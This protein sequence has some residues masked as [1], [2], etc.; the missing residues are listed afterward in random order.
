MD[1]DVELEAIIEKYHLGD[2]YPQYDA[3]KKARRF[4][5]NLLDELARKGEKAVFIGT[6]GTGLR[7]LRLMAPEGADFDF[8]SFQP[9]KLTA[10][11]LAGKKVYVV[12]WQGAGDIFE[13]L[14]A[15]N[16]SFQWLFDLL[17]ARGIAL[18]DEFYCFFQKKALQFPRSFE[19]IAAYEYY[20]CKKRHRATED[21]ELKKLLLKKMFFL[22][23]YM[24]NFLRAERM[25]KENRDEGLDMDAEKAWNEISDL[26]ERIKQALKRRDQA[27]IIFFWLDDLSHE[28]A[29]SVSYLQ[30]RRTHSYFFTEAYTMTP[31]TNPTYRSVFLGVRICSEV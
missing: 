18:D 3:T 16:V 23:L 31:H 25:L 8:F 10:E 28:R 7:Y 17:E 1:I 19:N 26:L 14:I 20:L 12:S 30:A 9:G 29:L 4:L 6:D 21:T 11:T 2:C 5:Q 15:L 22:T 24:R 13:E 27:D